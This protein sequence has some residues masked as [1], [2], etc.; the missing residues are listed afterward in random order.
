MFTWI[1]IGGGAFFLFALAV[2]SL[3]YLAVKND[4]KSASFGSGFSDKIAVVDLEGVIFE[5]KQ[6]ITN[7]K[8]Y[9]KDDSVKAIILNINSPG[10]GAEASKE[11]YQYVKRIADKHNK[12]K[13][14]PIVAVITS[15]GASGAYYAAAGSNKIYAND[16]SVVGSIGVIAQWVN[17]GDLMRWAKLKDVTL[18]AGDLK[19]AGSPWR[20]L[21]PAEHEYLQGVIDNMHQQFIHDVAVGRGMKDEDVKA[22][23]SGRIWTGQQAVPL[24]LIDQLADFQSALEDTAKSVGIKGEPTIIRPEK[25]KKT[26]YDILFGDLSDVLPD[27]A[28][29]MQEH[30]GFYYLWK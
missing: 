26:L 19:D 3:V 25:D 2:F 5:S 18:K 15:V 11:L 10:G 4:S 28:R 17:Y 21:T 6:V 22:I 13:T 8:K 20:D 30:V 1:V 14:K 9:E 23:A 27:K 12:E 7:L 16:S 29:M 24:K